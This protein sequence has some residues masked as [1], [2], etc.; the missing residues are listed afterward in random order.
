[1]E[2]Q[3]YL[4]YLQTLERRVYMLQN[5]DVAALKKLAYKYLS[6]DDFHEPEFVSGIIDTANDE[7]LTR[8]EAIIDV[9]QQ[10]ITRIGDEDTRTNDAYDQG[11]QEGYDDASSE[12]EFN[13]D[14][15]KVTS[16]NDG[17]NA[18]SKQAFAA[19]KEGQHND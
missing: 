3:I 13:L 19:Q 5:T 4:K 15:A 12:A 1:M 10:I 8:N 7:N 9:V 11:Y 17:F 18:G 14:E 16:Y 2:Y 6:A